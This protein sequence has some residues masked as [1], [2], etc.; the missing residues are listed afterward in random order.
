M[1]RGGVLSMHERACGWVYLK[2]VGGEVFFCLG[3]DT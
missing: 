2:L 3:L 1:L